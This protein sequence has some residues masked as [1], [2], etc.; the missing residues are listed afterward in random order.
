MTEA[1]E[2]IQ[3]WNAKFEELLSFIPAKLYSNEE[4]SN[5]WKQK[6]GTKKEQKERRMKKFSMDGLADET[7]SGAST[8]MEL[9]TSSAEK[10]AE[11]ISSENG[12]NESIL[13]LREKLAS[14]IQTLREQR[15]AEGPSKFASK[16]NPSTRD[17]KS[18]A[19]NKKKQKKASRGF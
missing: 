1:Q 10:D 8:P 19:K 9:D 2:R 15:R 12:G 18:P 4:T 17:Q 11:N 7:N 14:K 6:K 13:Q 16:R 5:Q 3:Q